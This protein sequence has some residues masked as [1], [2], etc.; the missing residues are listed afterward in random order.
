MRKEIEESGGMQKIYHKFLES[1]LRY[2][3]AKID[4][5]SSDQ[6]NITWEHGSII[7]Y[8]TIIVAFRE[9]M[10]R[11]KYGYAEKKWEFMKDKDQELMALTIM[12]EIE[13]A[14][15]Q[16]IETADS[17]L[18]KKNELNEFIIK[19]VVQ[20]YDK[21]ASEL[22]NYMKA[23]KSDIENLFVQKMFYYIDRFIQNDIIVH[24][25]E[26]VDK[27]PGKER[28][29]MISD[30]PN[31]SFLVPRSI[32]FGQVETKSLNFFTNNIMF[33]VHNDNNDIQVR[34]F[35]PYY[36][37]I[38]FCVN[39]FF[40]CHRRIFPSDMLNSILTILANKYGREYVSLYIFINEYLLKELEVWGENKEDG[41]IIGICNS[42]CYL[43]DIQDEDLVLKYYL[44]P[45]LTRLDKVEKDF[46]T[47]K[48]NL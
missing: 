2:P 39:L 3:R 17:T 24:H 21:N 30:N 37:G 6:I 8:M 12:K 7:N 26:L 42:F 5:V 46:S 14:S 40:T 41:R 47:Y 32:M 27:I 29:V 31:F 19:G 15:G 9:V 35:N 22:E 25:Y 1:I 18:N 10:V 38:T 48:N 34:Y 44:D 16:I 13:K 23:N 43:L 11:W 20:E 4:K 36:F 45:L 33:K 28:I